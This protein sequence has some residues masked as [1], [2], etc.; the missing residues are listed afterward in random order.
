LIV[1]ELL[2]KLGL[3]SDSL[4]R[5]MAEAKSSLQNFGASID[6]SMKAALPASKTLAAGI[7]GLGASL[8]GASV[9][10]VQLAGSMEQAKIAFTTM[11]GSAEQADE[12]I[13][14]LWDFA[15]KTPFE[16]EGLTTSARQLLAY[17]FQA[18]EILPMMTAIGDAISALGGGT[19]EI[20]RVTRALGQMQAKGKVTA[21]EMMQLAELGIP[22]WEILAEEIGVSI[23]EAMEKASKGGIDAATGINAILE[24]MSKRF[25]GAMEQQSESLLGLWETAKDTV[26]G[27][28]RT[29]G[30]N[31][32]ETFDLKDKLKGAIDALDQFADALNKFFELVSEKGIRQALEEMLPEGMEEKIVIIAGAIIGA[33]VPAMYAFAT[34]VITATLPLLPFIA[35][36]AAIAV[37]AYQIYD[38]WEPITN[39]FTNAWALI[40][41]GAEAMFIRVQQIWYDLQK[42]AGEAIMAILD[43]FAPLVEWLP[44][45]ISDGFN[46][47]REAVVNELGIVYTR[48]EEL[49][50]R[51]EETSKRIQ[52]AMAG[53][54]QGARNARM[55]LDAV[56]GY[57]T[58][59]RT[60]LGAGQKATTTQVYTPGI[61]WHQP[62]SF[63]GGG[64]V[65]G[66]IG[67]PVPA[68]VHG[69]EYIFDPRGGNNPGH[70][71]QTANIII[72]LDGR[73]LARAI[74]QPLVDELRVKQGLRI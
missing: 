68:I 52:T 13:R 53:I 1:G 67:M 70:G 18:R 62:L 39:F 44:D 46:R 34:S 32:I 64:I 51:S 20:D 23:P 25:S 47:M 15:A 36:G 63:Q 40:T 49:S 38:N 9:K 54:A 56:H 26:S 24:G 28:L 65:P 2:V 21:E 35:A 5:G 66:P 19:V 43:F 50:D 60:R 73:V 11:L 37:L 48:L 8:L 27:I 33:L 41:A 74:G 57:D 16:F 72:E 55:E 45:S 30:Q 10:G 58:S 3:D 7:V 29:L 69:G 6:R 59:G 42:R 61:G 71:K 31:I 12:F 14:D 17:G 4:K 22:V